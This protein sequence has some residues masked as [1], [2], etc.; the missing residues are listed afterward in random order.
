MGGRIEG[1]VAIVTGGANGLGAAI[2]RRFVDEGAKVV[3]ADIDVDAGERLV[4]ELGANTRFRALDVGDEQQWA[5]AIAFTL[6]EFGRLDVGVNNGGIVMHAA[7]VD[8]ELAD[9]ERMVRVNQIGTFL[10]MRAMAG[11]MKASGGGS[12]IN[13]SSVRGIQGANGLLGYAATKFAVRGMTKVAALELGHHGI[14]VNSIHPGAVATRLI[15]DADPADVDKYFE[16][17]A[18]PRIARPYEIANMALFLASDESSYSTGS[19]FVCDGGV[20]AGVRRPGAGF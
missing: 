20:T 19:E 6:D 16:D 10:G 14:R 3:V 2:V 5:D 12:I 9:Y 13:T 17:Q 8:M 7:L 4:A 11:P 15:G 18:I 1:R